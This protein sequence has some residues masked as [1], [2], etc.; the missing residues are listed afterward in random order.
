MPIDDEAASGVGNPDE[1]REFH[2]H[3][4]ELRALAKSLGVFATFRYRREESRRPIGIR[5]LQPWMYV[6]I[7]A[8]GEIAPC[9]AVFGSD[10]CAVMGS[11][12]HEEFESIWR[13]D[14][15][16]EFRTTCVSGTNDLCLSCSYY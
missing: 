1:I 8:T 15:Y 11:V 2:R 13:G 4:G 3:E 16:R 9:C 10:K 6:F 7:R 12:V 14:R 5:C